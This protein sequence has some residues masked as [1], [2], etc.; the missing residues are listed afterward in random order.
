[1]LSPAAYVLR[2]QTVFSDAPGGTGKIFLLNLIH[3]FSSL[4]VKKG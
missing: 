4:R 3:S 2:L 1:M